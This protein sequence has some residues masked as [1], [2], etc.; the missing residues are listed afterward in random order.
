MQLR[1]PATSSP[2]VSLIVPCFNMGPRL[3]DTIASLQAQTYHPTEIIIVDDGSTEP[4]TIAYLERYRKSGLQIVR[5][6]NSGLAAA[7]NAGVAASE[8]LFFMPLGDDLIEPAYVAEAVEVLTKNPKIGIVYCQ[9]DLFGDRQ[10]PWELPP[11]TMKRQLMDNCIFATALFR[12]CDWETAGGY[13]ITMRH[14]RED[15]DFIMRILSLGRTTHRLDGVYFHYRRGA[16]SIND[17]LAQDRQHL[18]EAHATIMRNNAELYLDHADLLWER[19]F[20]L[21]DERNDLRHRYQ[22]LERL[23]SM[24]WAREARGLRNRLRRLKDRRHRSQ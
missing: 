21:V 12:R 14:G 22:R 10:G 19:I 13:D 7:L 24:R 3:L 17:N 18:I 8:G 9:A 11:F 4:K 16:A 2:L 6:Q 1:P 5:Q 15:H 20:E 23:R